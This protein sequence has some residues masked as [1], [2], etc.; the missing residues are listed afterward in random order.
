MT[1]F[2]LQ[3]VTMWQTESVVQGLTHI[4]LAAK[5]T[6]SPVSV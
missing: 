2:W 5:I 4:F 3:A 1:I 6:E